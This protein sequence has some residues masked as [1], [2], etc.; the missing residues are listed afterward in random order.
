MDENK[1]INWFY[2]LRPYSPFSEKFMYI[3]TR[4]F[5]AD[6]LFEDAG[7]KVTK[8]NVFFRPGES[9][10]VVIA[11]CRKR[12]ITPVMEAL[13]LLPSKALV[14]GHYDYMDY[15]NNFLRESVVVEED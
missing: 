12:D 8:L 15:A 1:K 2:L 7:A 6:R 3:D 11:K 5:L 13:T 14:C 9:Y 10:R 4:N